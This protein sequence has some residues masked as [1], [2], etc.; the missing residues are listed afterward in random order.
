MVKI[1]IESSLGTKV[2]EGEDLCYTCLVSNCEVDGVVNDA[3]YLESEATYIDRVDYI[4]TLL[5]E[6]EGIYEDVKLIMERLRE[7]N[8]SNKD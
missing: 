6:E 8:D 4:V 5:Q 1:T 7:L 3:I 2:F